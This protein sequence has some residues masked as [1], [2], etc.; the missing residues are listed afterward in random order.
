[1]VHHTRKWHQPAAALA[2]LAS[3]APLALMCSTGEGRRSQRVAS[4]QD[5]FIF[6]VIGLG[7]GEENMTRKWDERRRGGSAED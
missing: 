6:N 3:Q 4:A 1:M 7:V 2:I 5:K